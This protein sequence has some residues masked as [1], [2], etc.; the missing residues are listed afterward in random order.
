MLPYVPSCRLKQLAFFHRGFVFWEPWL[1]WVLPNTCELVLPTLLLRSLSDHF[2]REPTAT[3][4]FSI[5]KS[6]VWS[7]QW[8]HNFATVW[9]QIKVTLQTSNIF[10]SWSCYHFVDVCGLHIQFY[11][12]E[13][14]RVYISKYY[15]QN[16]GRKMTTSLKYF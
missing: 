8:V 16:I 6:D 2:H 11:V 13:P 12:F 3:K 9:V 14:Y 7:S 4:Y 10:Y 15:E 1:W 5:L